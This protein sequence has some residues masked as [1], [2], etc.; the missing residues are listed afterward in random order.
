MNLGRSEWQVRGIRYVQ[1]LSSVLCPASNPM[2]GRAR[3]VPLT[4]KLMFSCQ[5]IRKEN[6]QG[7][8]AQDSILL[9]HLT[10]IVR[11][12]KIHCEKSLTDFQGNEFVPPCVA[13]RCWDSGVS[14][15]LPAVWFLPPGW[16]A[17]ASI[18]EFSIKIFSIKS[19]IYYLKKKEKNPL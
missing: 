9:Q 18:Q 2:L 5:E 4:A 8:R 3:M 13:R 6:K 15:W 1:V 16:E 17:K 14:E 12:K 10:S 19:N 7:K 11:G